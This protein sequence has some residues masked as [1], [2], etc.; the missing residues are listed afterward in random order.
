MSNILT[1]RVTICGLRPLLWHSFGLD[2]IPLEKKE[3]TGVA[4][5]DPTEWRRT[6]LLTEQRLPYLP[7]TYLFGAIKDGARFT[8][9]GRGSLQPLVVST[10]QMHDERIVLGDQPLPDPLTTDPTQPLYLDIRSVRNPTTKGRNVRYRVA[11]TPGWELTFTMAWDRTVVSRTEMESVLIDAGRLA[12]VGSGR[13][14]GF[15]RFALRQ[16]AVTGET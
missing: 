1:A 9:R 15:G 14:I 11:A 5:N 4:G 16:F 2:A 6:V 12:G 10:L 8:K 13:Q 3:R 7:G